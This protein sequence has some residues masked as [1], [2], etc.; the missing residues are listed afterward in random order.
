MV[1]QICQTFL[2]YGMITDAVMPHTEEPN[3]E[4]F[5]GKTNGFEIKCLKLFNINVTEF[6]RF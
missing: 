4:N 6:V 1:H 3:L 5:L 2:L